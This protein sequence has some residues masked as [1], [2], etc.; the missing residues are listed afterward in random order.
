MPGS[1]GKLPGALIAWLVSADTTEIV[2]V[3]DVS[4]GS[5][6]PILSLS[7]SMSPCSSSAAVFFVTVM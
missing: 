7:I 3:C 6:P 4:A 1:T 5:N 2:I